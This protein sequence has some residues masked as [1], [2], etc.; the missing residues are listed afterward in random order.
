MAPHAGLACASP[1]GLATL[2]FLNSSQPMKI[3]VL[4]RETPSPQTRLP[5]LNFEHSPP[6][7]GRTVEDEVE[8][9]GAQPAHGRRRGD[10]N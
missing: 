6:V 8:A 9:Q 3:V 1:S 5:A 7:Y 2:I 4:D 10:W